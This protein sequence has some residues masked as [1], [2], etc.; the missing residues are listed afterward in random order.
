MIDDGTL[1]MVLQATGLIC[2]IASIF[3]DGHTRT[4][5]TLIA[6]LNAGLSGMFA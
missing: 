5:L 2:L 6:I 4:Y 3:A 1:D